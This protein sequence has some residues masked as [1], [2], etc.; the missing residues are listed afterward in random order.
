MKILRQMCF[1]GNAFLRPRAHRSVSRFAQKFACKPFD[2]ACN[3]VF[4]CLRMSVR[5]C[6]ASWVNEAK[7]GNLL[8]VKIATDCSVCR[9]IWNVKKS[10][11]NLEQL[12]WKKENRLNSKIIF[13]L[14]Y[15]TIHPLENHFERIGRLKCLS[16]CAGRSLFWRH[17]AALQCCG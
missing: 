13:F 5:R 4:D 2:V 3:N 12:R 15:A 14:C 7:A 10:L 17:Q 11:Q 1:F 6:S 8:S 16:N 9:G